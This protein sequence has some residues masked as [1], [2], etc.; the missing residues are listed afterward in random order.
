MTSG[1]VTGGAS[2]NPLTSSR[3]TIPAITD[4]FDLHIDGETVPYPG[5]GEVLLTEK[6]AELTDIKTGDTVTGFR[7]G[8]GKSRAQGRGFS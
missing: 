5:K 2:Q 7:F 3:P 4:I 1:D 8:H 6:L